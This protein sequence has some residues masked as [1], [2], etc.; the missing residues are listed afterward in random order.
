MDAKRA[1]YM[2]R[3]IQLDSDL[4]AA[5]SRSDHV[6]RLYSSEEIAHK[7]RFAKLKVKALEA[8]MNKKKIM[9]SHVKIA[10]DYLN[11]VA[12]AWDSGNPD[13]QEEMTGARAIEDTLRKK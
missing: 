9:D 13:M 5:I 2:R 4:L 10:A 8:L 3:S 1:G 7:K 11:A 6:R 12:D